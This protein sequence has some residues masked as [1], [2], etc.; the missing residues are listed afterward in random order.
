MTSESANDAARSRGAFWLVCGVRVAAG[1]VV[2]SAYLAGDRRPVA[3]DCPQAAAAKPKYSYERD[4][5][6]D[7]AEAIRQPNVCGTRASAAVVWR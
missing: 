4:T 2:I 3:G 7:S 5:P 6:R 1:L